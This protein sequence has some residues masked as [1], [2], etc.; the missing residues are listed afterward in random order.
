MRSFP[1]T[2]DASRATIDWKYS[3]PGYDA[4]KQHNPYFIGPRSELLGR[5][6][7]E[8]SITPGDGQFQFLLRSGKPDPSRANGELRYDPKTGVCPCNLQGTIEGKGLAVRDEVVIAVN[9]VIQSIT[10]LLPGSPGSYLF[11]SL[12]LDSA[13]QSGSNKVGLYRVVPGV[14]GGLNL[15]ELRA[16]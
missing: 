9:G 3:L 16:L 11:A 12:I 4:P 7:K 15:Q 1:V 8:F 5:H 14:S 2:S 10:T 13:F 6:V